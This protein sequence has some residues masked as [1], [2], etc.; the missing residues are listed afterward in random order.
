MRTEVTEVKVKV[1]VPLPEEL[2]APCL[3]PVIEGD[4][5][6]YGDLVDITLETMGTVESCNEQLEAI[7]KLQ[8]TVAP[9]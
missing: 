7:R 5:I 1:Y 8:D 4:V 6:T 9:L 2:T 3:V